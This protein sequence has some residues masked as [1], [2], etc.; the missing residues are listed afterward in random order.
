[1]PLNYWRLLILLFVSANDCHIHRGNTGILIL[2]LYLLSIDTN[3][4]LAVMKSNQATLNGSTAS[5]SSYSGSTSSLADRKPT[6]TAG[7]NEAMPAIRA[8]LAKS[9]ATLRASGARP[10]GSGP[11]AA[12]GHGT[13]HQNPVL[14]VQEMVGRVKVTIL[15]IC[16]WF[17]LHFSAS[18]LALRQLLTVFC[19]AS[20]LLF[21]FIFLLC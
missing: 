17:A 5:L 13:P 20:L 15:H 6:A 10:S 1:M 9:G 2:V 21:S 18:L 11:G 7:S 14:M 19:S 12:P 16:V 4:E 3:V 8:R